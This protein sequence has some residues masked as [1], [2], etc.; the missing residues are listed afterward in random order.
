M[1]V[2]ASLRKFPQNVR[3]G[4]DLLSQP[5]L[6][7]IIVITG[8]GGGEPVKDRVGAGDVSGKAKVLRGSDLPKG[9]E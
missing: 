2:R 1:G 6:R 5:F 3:K 9:G 7:G 4:V 8:V